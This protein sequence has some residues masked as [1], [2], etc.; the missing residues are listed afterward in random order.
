MFLAVTKKLEANSPLHPL[1]SGI[2]S[3]LHHLTNFIII[4]V[5]VSTLVITKYIPGFH[6]KLILSILHECEFVFIT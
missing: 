3:I 6:G 2:Q 5:I 4:C 1:I